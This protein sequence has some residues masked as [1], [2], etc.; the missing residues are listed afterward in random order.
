MFNV[1]ANLPL[2]AVGENFPGVTIVRIVRDDLITGLK[3]F[4]PI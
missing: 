3:L 1:M 2:N 4:F